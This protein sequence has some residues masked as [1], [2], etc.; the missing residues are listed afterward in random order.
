[1]RFHWTI[2]I[3]FL[4]AAFTTISYI[5]QVMKTLKT[6]ETKDISLLMFVI[7]S[8][9]LFLWLVYGILLN[10]LPIIIANGIT[11]VLASVVLFLKIRYG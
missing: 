3:G 8:S 11:L 5:P 1:M 10:D 9:G 7:L 4:A 6:R 2:A